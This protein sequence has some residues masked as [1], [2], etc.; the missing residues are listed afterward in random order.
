MIWPSAGEATVEYATE[1]WG[2]RPHYRGEVSHL[3][4]DEFGSW[5]WGVS[6]RTMYRGDDSTFVTEQPVLI[7]IAG[8]AWW[9]VSW[10]VGHPD[11]DLYVNICTPAQWA[12]ERIVAVD[13]DLDVI[14]YCDG[15]VAVVD[16]DEFEHH[17]L[18]YDYPPFIIEG[19]EQA[20][21]SAYE[22]V[23]DNAAPFDGVAAQTWIARGTAGQSAP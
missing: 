10:W 3:G 8:D 21:A 4:D 16:R 20:T 2:G 19:A 18:L 22:L 1:K 9:S 11:V 14:R 17:Q 7:L 6:G 12:G 15:R 5:L 23:V 13:V